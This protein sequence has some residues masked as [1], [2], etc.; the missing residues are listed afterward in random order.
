MDIPVFDAYLYSMID[1]TKL[2]ADDWIADLDASDAEIEAG[3]FVDGEVV[4]DKLRAALKRMEARRP[5]APQ[6]G[7]RRAR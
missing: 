7:N 1:P 3:L 6:R 2:T 5:D 4:A